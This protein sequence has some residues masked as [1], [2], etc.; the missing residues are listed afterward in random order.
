MFLQ[1]EI[2][3]NKDSTPYRIYIND[4][5]IT[6]RFYALPP[7]LLT[8]FTADN[9]SNVLMFEIKDAEGYNVTIENISGQSETN[10]WISDVK[11]QSVSFNPSWWD[12]IDDPVAA[13]LKG[14][15]LR[16]FREKYGTK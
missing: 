2:K 10:I 4:E 16:S 11:T 6:E 15:A 5:L 13:G 9:I 7:Y 3:C 14:E 8:K 1:A 12:G